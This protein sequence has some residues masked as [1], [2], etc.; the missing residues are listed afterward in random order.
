MIHII[1]QIRITLFFNSR[2]LCNRFPS[3]VA[4]VASVATAFDPFYATPDFV[5][6]SSDRHNDTDRKTNTEDTENTESFTFNLSLSTFNSKVVKVVKVKRAFC[7]FQLS[8]LSFQSIDYRLSTDDCPVAA[9]A[10]AVLVVAVLP[11]RPVLGQ[12]G[13]WRTAPMRRLSHLVRLRV[14]FW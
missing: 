12:T 7:D 13:G 14:N 3:F 1:R 2:I 5:S 6:S 10:V 9:A 8:A 11:V 4:K